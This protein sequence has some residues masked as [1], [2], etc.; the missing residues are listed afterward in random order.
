MS[1]DFS[2]IAAQIAADFS[3]ELIVETTPILGKGIVNL[4]FRVLSAS[5]AFVIRLNEDEI[6]FDEYEK[7]RWCIEQ[8]RLMGVPCPAVLK[9]GKMGDI[10]Y[11]IEA[12]VEGENGEDA[13]REGIWQI[14]GG[15]SRLINSIKTSPPSHQAR[16][17]NFRENWPAF[18]AYNITSLNKDDRLLDLGVFDINQSAEIKRRIEALQGRDYEFGL[19]HT[20]IV[21]RNTIVEPSGWVVLLDWGSAKVNIVPHTELAA[22]LDL[23]LSDQINEAEFKAFLDGYGLSWAEYEQVKPEVEI[24]LLL[25]SIDTVRWAID[26]KPERV[27]PL[28]AE[29]RKVRKVILPS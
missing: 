18:L 28:A 16:F 26:R 14:L 9:I 6:Y 12:L 1:P 27:Q 17:Y 11:M 4:V 22:L 23:R 8:A 21:P 2:W 24:L 15:Y 3:V 7:E 25:R 19:L 10:P 5:Q 13:D 20:D 29:A